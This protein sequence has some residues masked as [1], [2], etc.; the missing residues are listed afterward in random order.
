MYRQRYDPHP[1]RTA[2]HYQDD[3][4]SEDRDSNEED[5]KGSSSFSYCSTVFR[6]FFFLITLAFLCLLIYALFKYN[7]DQVRDACPNLLTFM[8]IRTIAGLIFFASL[9][10]FILCRSDEPSPLSPSVIIGFFVFY[11]LSFCIAGGVIIPQS[12][13]GNSNCVDKALHD[14]TF[15]I[16]LLGILGWVYLG[17]D[18][19][20]AIMFIVTL[21]SISTSC[22]VKSATSEGQTNN[23]EDSDA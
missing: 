14:S 22:C 20:F 18:G 16:P 3:S 4:G 9:I 10:T 13:I 11:F 23:D 6:F 2:S 8:I 21:I 17:L 12:M 5:G 1:P 19:I 15:Q 7:T